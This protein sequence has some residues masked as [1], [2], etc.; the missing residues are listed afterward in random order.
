[1]KIENKTKIVTTIGPASDSLIKIEELISAGTDVFRFNTK[2]STTE[3]HNE[4]IERV[5]KIAEKLK[6]HIGIMIDLQGNEVRIQTREEKNIMARQ[7]SIIFIGNS[8]DNEEAS[9]VVPDAKVFKKLKKG[10]SI[11]IDDGSIILEVIENKKKLI[12]AKIIDGGVIK[13]RKSL[14]FPGANIE[15]SSLIKRDMDH[16]DATAKK[17]VTFVALSFVTSKKDIQIL[18]KELIKRK[19][20]ALIVAKI[21]NQQAI[22]NIDE[23]IKEADAIMVARGDLGIEIPIESIAFWQKEIIKKCRKNRKPV[24]VATQ[25]LHSMIENPR[26]TRAEV[27][28]VANATLDG[29]DAVMLSEETALGKHPVKAVTILD[30]IIKFNED[31]AVFKN[32]QSQTLTPTELLIGSIIKEIE[33]N[34]NISKKLKIKTA[35][36]FTETGYTAKVISSFRSKIKVVAITKQGHTAKNLSL[37]YGIMSYCI[38]SEQEYRQNSNQA[39][40]KLCSPVFLSS[41]SCD[42]LSGEKEIDSFCLPKEILK[43]LKDKKILTQNETIIIFHGQ[44]TKKPNLL[45]L[46]SL[47]KI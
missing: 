27:T 38:L 28:D 35:I 36:V 3:W 42:S 24:I 12:E 46:C 31:K 11:S 44:Q 14:N 7:D 32:N 17:N 30:K 6:K 20:P 16:L 40:S 15:L 34:E 45:S 5:Q 21:E 29:T 18:K 39:Q 2:H 47:M 23:I 8:F 4:R 41:L 13:N 10:N 1:M 19:M 37:S 22:D 26:P 25:M 43:D 33:N 9:V